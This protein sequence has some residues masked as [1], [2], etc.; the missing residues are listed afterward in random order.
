MPHLVLDIYKLYVTCSSVFCRCLGFQSF[1]T[2]LDREPGIPMLS[3]YGRNFGG[4]KSGRLCFPCHYIIRADLPSSQ[5]LE[6]AQS[7]L[8]Q[9]DARRLVIFH[10]IYNCIK[11]LSTYYLGR[12]LQCRAVTDCSG[13]FRFANLKTR[14]GVVTAIRTSIK[15]RRYLIGR[16]WDQKVNASL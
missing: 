15:P 6:H 2:D 4:I 12:T 7:A 14:I 5:C 1:N 3:R 8:Y 9:F 10:V 16:E 13:P 11:S